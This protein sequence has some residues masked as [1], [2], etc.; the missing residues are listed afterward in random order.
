MVALTI[1]DQLELL[2]IARER[3][4]GVIEILEETLTIIGNDEQGLI[5]RDKLEEALV[6]LQGPKKSSNDG[7]D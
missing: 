6:A 2:R 4:D 1:E 3:L 5:V 7:N